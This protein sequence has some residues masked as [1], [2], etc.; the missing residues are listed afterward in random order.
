M[1]S[2]LITLVEIGSEINYLNFACEFSDRATVEQA[3]GYCAGVRC[4]DCWFNG[5]NQPNSNKLE[6]LFKDIK[7]ES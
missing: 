6:I 2:K 3:P 7:N 5:M 1:K 4:G